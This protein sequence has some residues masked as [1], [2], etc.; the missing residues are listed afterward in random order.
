VKE[1]RRMGHFVATKAKELQITG[2]ELAN[3]IGCSAEKISALFKGRLM[4][5]YPQIELLA[6][7]LLVSPENIVHGDN[8]AYDTDFVHCM[9]TF[10]EKDNREKILDFI[11]TYIDICEAVGE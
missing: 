3:G 1:F 5:S 6:T 4:L 10:K 7:L 8:T 9:A 2:E 11:D